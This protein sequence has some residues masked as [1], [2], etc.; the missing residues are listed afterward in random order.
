MTTPAPA[1]ITFPDWYQG[2]YPDVEMLMQLLFQPLL[3]TVQNADGSWTPTY[4]V[5]WLPTPD[6]YNPWLDNGCAY[7]RAYRMGGGINYDNNSDEPRV[8]IAAVT[9]RR[10]DSWYLIEFV[11]QVLNAYQRGGT[12]PGAPGVMLYMAGEVVG[13]Q[14]VPEIIQDDRLVQI[15][16]GFRVKKPTPD[17]KKF[18]D[19]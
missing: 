15:T 6:V 12:V 4:V 2:G 1:N 16:V 9:R 14:Q 18:L 10:D 3:G 19:I 17:Y 5:T 11:R 7:L 13:P 8:A